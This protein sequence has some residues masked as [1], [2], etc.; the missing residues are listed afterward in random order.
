MT[1][2]NTD[3]GM[4]EENVGQLL[5]MY[6]SR[7][8]EMQRLIADLNKALVVLEAEVDMLRATDGLK[9]ATCTP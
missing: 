4:V 2:P 5:D 3:K 7:Q 8:A 1:D 9:E 6:R